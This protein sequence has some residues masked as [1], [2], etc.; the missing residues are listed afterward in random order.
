MLHEVYF[1]NKETG[2]LLPAGEAIRDYYKTHGPLDRWTDMWEETGM[3]VPGR[4]I[5]APD[6]SGTVN[7]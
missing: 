3:E 7:L 1:M 2:E 4:Y 6:F 5:T